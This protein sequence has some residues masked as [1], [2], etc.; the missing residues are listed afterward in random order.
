MLE[1]TCFFYVLSKKTA[2]RHTPVCT[3]LMSLNKSS[4]SIV[5]CPSGFSLLSCGVENNQPL[6]EVWRHA[7]PTSPTTC[8]CYDFYG[9][10]CKAWC[11]TAISGFEI[12]SNLHQSGVFGVSCPSGKKVKYFFSTDLKNRRSEKAQCCEAP[13]FFFLDS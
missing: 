12:V 2:A 7:I 10:F 1:S 4:V 11:S 13:Q 6:V 5:T 8:E 9:A 3:Q